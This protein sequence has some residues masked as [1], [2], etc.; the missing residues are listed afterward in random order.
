MR[1]IREAVEL[2]GQPV[3]IGLA[4]PECPSWRPEKMETPRQG[5]AALSPVV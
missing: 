5:G 4:L 1:A 3:E 2:D